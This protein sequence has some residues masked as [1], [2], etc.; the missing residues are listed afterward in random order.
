MKLSVDKNKCIGCGVCVD[1]AD[2]ALEIKDGHA[3]PIEKA[4]L[5]NKEISES[6]NMAM[7]VCPMQAISLS[8]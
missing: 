5:S 2:Q 6:V 4:D 1:V 7:E 8:K 3:S